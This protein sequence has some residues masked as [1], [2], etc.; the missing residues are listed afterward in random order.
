MSRFE[1]TQAIHLD[2]LSVEVQLAESS[3]GRLV[4][5]KLGEDEYAMSPELA[6]RLGKGLCDAAGDVLAQKTAKVS[7]HG[8][9]S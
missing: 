2:A 9:E 4:A 8:G 1:H 3:H 5:M 6:A 7:A